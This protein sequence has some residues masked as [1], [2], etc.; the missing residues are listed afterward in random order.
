[1]T[2]AT[3]P[4]PT[5][6]LYRVRIYLPGGTMHVVTEEEPVCLGVEEGDCS[7]ALLGVREDLGD[8][9]GAIDWSAVQAVSWRYFPAK[10]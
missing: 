2:V 3:S 4:D 9:I 6:A 10:E 7:T 1:M 5:I 8:T